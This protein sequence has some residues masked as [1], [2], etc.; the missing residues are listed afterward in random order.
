V[1]AP[2]WAPHGPRNRSRPSRKIRFKV[3]CDAEW[4]LPDARRTVSGAPKGNKNAFKHG[5]YT[6]QSIARRRDIA[7]LLAGTK[8]L[9]G[10]LK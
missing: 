7:K 6:G 1:P 9:L 2:H 8:G 4:P 3:P 5:G 10:E